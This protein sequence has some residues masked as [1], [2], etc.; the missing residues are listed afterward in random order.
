MVHRKN[1]WP[2]EF[3]AT[4]SH[5]LREHGR[6]RIVSC[7]RLPD[8]HGEECGAVT[9]ASMKF[10]IGEALL[11]TADDEEIAS[12][13]QH[14]SPCSSVIGAASTFNTVSMRKRPSVSFASFARYTWPTLPSPSLATT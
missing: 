13:P 14:S 10:E 7:S 6:E 5:R 11:R 8:C 1:L 9:N 4:F 2:S 3:E 12:S